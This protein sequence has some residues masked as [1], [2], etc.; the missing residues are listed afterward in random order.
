MAPRAVRE[1]QIKKLVGCTNFRRSNPRSDLFEVQKFHHVEFWCP[2]A[3]NAYKRFQIGLGMSLVTRSGN[4]LYASFVTQSNDLV[5]AFTTPYPSSIA[6]KESAPTRGFDA[7]ACR[8]FVMEQGFGVRAVG[9]CVGDAREAFDISVAHGA[10]PVCP[11]VE[12]D[13]PTSGT[14]QVL[15]EV[16]L[17]GRVVLRFVSGDY[18]G[19]FLAG[20]ERVDGPQ[21]SYGLSRLDHAVGNVENLLDAVNYVVGFTGFHE[22]AEFTAEDV[23]T[24]DSGLNSM[25]LANN[26]ELVLLPV[27]EPTYG[28]KRR[29]Q[30]QTYLDLNCGPGVQHL[31]LKTDDIFSTVREMRKYSETGGFDFMPKPSEGYYRELPA[32]IGSVLTPKQYEEVEKLGLLVDKDDQ[33]VLLQVFTQPCSDR[34]TIFLEIIQRVGCEREVVMPDGNPKIQQSGGCGGFGKGNF[35]ELFK[36]V[37]DYEKSL[38]L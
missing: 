8:E 29:S 6:V 15:S 3:T 36:S 31:A 19:P 23:G 28:T 11:P 38:G 30:I 14:K 18:D 32:R 4:S 7:E 27:N 35:T 17:Y 22:F 21:L 1:P 16:K 37:E 9:V 2:D 33:G 25:V 5:F 26:N 20:F 34:P 12:L 24:V 10:V 13:D